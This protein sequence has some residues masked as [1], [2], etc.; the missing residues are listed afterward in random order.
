M[1]KYEGLKEYESNASTKRCELII[2]KCLYFGD[3]AALNVFVTKLI[4]GS[5][6]GRIVGKTLQASDHKN[7]FR[8]F[9]IFANR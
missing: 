3:I 2:S 6:T 7:Y 8:Y 9:R 1:Q 5:T 4:K